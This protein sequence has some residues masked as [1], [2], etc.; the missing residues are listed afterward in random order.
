MPQFVAPDD[1]IEKAITIM[2]LNDFSQLP[3]LDANKHARGI[4]RWPTII[5]ALLDAKPAGRAADWAGE[6][7]TMHHDRSIY[8]AFEEVLSYEY[9]LVTEDNTKVCGIVTAYDLGIYAQETLV[10]YMLV[11]EIELA[12]RG[13]IDKF[14]LDSRKQKPPERQDKGIKEEKVPSLG[15]LIRILAHGD[16]WQK[17][18]TRMSQAEVLGVMDAVRHYRNA[19]MH[20][21][22]QTGPDEDGA[23]LDMQWLKVIARFFGQTG[24]DGPEHRLMKAGS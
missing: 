21:N 22:S 19:I 6:A 20:F 2:L 10:P 24:L 13:L 1:G 7:R 15:E 5:K 18:K 17:L 16:N 14:Q 23:R 12:L 9:V 3:V 8:D 11:E 4:L